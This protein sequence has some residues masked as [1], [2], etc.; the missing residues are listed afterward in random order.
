[1]KVSICIGSACHLNGSRQVVEQLQQL[2][3]AHDLDDRVELEG[4]LCKGSCGRGVCVMVDDERFYVQPQN[5]EE[6]FL[7]TI[8]AREET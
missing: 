3:A 7:K 2:V 6:F 8:L 4:S 1:M 5:V